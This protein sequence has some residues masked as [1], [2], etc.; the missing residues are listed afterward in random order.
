MH[1]IYSRQ[2]NKVTHVTHNNYSFILIS[3]CLIAFYFIYGWGPFTDM[4]EKVKMGETIL[5]L[6]KESPREE[7][8]NI[9]WAEGGPEHSFWP[10][11][12][13]CSGFV[14]RFAKVRS[15]PTHALVSYPGSGNTWIRYL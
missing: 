11:D 12:E 3:S 9:S 8:I 10:K 13:S 14:T 2:L 1:C 15:I 5:R 4:E 7:R 6:Q